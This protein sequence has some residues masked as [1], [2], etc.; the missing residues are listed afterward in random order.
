M[1]A[2][3]AMAHKTKEEWAKLFSLPLHKMHSEAFVCHGNLL[4]Q[5]SRRKDAHMYWQFRPFCEEATGRLTSCWEKLWQKWASKDIKQSRLTRLLL[6]QTQKLLVQE[7]VSETRGRRLDACTRVRRGSSSAPSL[8]ERGAAESQA[9]LQSYNQRHIL[10]PSWITREDSEALC[11]CLPSICCTSWQNPSESFTARS[12]KPRQAARWLATRSS[13][14]G[15]SGWGG[16][17]LSKKRVLIRHDWG[18]QC[19]QR[20]EFEKTYSEI[21]GFVASRS[22]KGK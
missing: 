21:L 6:G 22:Q 10:S 16:H 13:G 8:D 12:I 17:S 3:R 20:G 1:N 2:A 9:C 5:L 11:H 14:E 7:A 18:S 4:P 15:F 19:S